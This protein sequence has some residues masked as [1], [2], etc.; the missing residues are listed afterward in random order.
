MSK[1]TVKEV[2]RIVLSYLLEKEHVKKNTVI[3]G[4]LNWADGSSIQFYSDSTTERN[5]I[6]LLY[7]LHSPD[8]VID[9]KV[10]LTYVE[11]NLGRGMVPYFIYPASGRRCRI[12]YKAF[13]SPI[14]KAR[15][16]YSERLYY[17]SQLWSKNQR[18]YGQWYLAEK[19]LREL[20]TGVRKQTTYNGKLTRR[21]KAELNWERKSLSTGLIF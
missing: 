6:R 2:Y 19:R 5:Y 15:Q 3:S 7:R 21:R 8:Q 13:G 11:S 14:W 20:S 16:A 9:Y 17:E 12:L 18:V 4:L 1:L 10:Y